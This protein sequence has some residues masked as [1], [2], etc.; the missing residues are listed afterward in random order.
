M[1]IASIIPSVEEEINNILS[2]IVDF[3]I[4]LQAEDKSINAYIAYSE[5]D[6]WP[7]EL[8]SG[9]EKFVA[10]LAIRTSLINVSSLPKPNFLAIDEGFGAL[11]SSNLN[12]M[13]MLFDYLKTQFKFI[14]IISHIDS[15]RDIV[16]SHIEIN[17]TNGKSKIAHP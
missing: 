7:L 6:F 3:S 10:S 14:M 16:D 13:V 9:M 11:D 1:L 17:K 8:T 5:D 4:V 15:M 2:Q 12:S